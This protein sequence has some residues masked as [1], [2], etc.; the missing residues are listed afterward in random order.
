MTA[1]C[2][3]PAECASVLEEGRKE[4][5]RYKWIKSEKAGRDL[6]QAAIDEWSRLHWWPHLRHCWFLHLQGI[7]Y[8]QEFD[9]RDFG[10]LHREFTDPQD[11]ELL[12]Q[13]VERIYYHGAENLDIILWAQE[14]RVDMERVC[15][16]L[17]RLDI[18][19]RR[20]RCNFP[21]EG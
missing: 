6:G 10:L 8:Y 13:I 1:A 20:L 7:R 11:R 2:S 14:N 19:T 9:E 15:L 18:N 3:L 17:E 4:A 5:L 12:R 16:I 21:L